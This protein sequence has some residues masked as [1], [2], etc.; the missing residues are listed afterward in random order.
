MMPHTTF[1]TLVVFTFTLFMLIGF[2]GCAVKKYQNISYLPAAG[3]E[4]EEPTLNVFAPRKA[5][6]AKEPLPVMVFVHGGNWNSG[7]KEMYNLL[8]RHFARKGMV[9]VLPGYNLSPQVNYDTMTH[10]I[11]KAILWTQQNINDYGGQPNRIFLTGHSAGVHLIALATM[12]PTYGIDP[13]SISGMI[14]NDGAGLDM[15]DY[16][17][18]NPPTNEDNYLA[19]WSNNPEI[20][21]KASPIFYVNENTPPI[22]LYLGSKTYPSITRSNN[23]FL[24][25]IKPHQPELTTIVLD[26]K[27]IPMVLQYFWPWSKRYKEI[28]QFMEQVTAVRQH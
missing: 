15:Y 28:Q 21:K 25:A 12:N 23:R 13:K 8:G 6:K 24:K 4:I 2:S 10:Q 1:S 20:W 17:T 14:F 27:H 22:L 5:K 16:L 26:K 18:R 11:A 7:S 19:T 3:S 9:A